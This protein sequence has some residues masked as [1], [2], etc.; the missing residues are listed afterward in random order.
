L[1]G[2]ENVLDT[3]ELAYEDYLSGMKYKDIADKHGLTLSAVKSRATRIWSNRKHSSLPKLQPKEK[4]LHP[5]KPDKARKQAKVADKKVATNENGETN[6]HNPKAHPGNKHAVGNKGGSGGPIGNKRALI[7][8]AYETILFDDLTDEQRA[9]IAAVTTDIESSHMAALQVAVARE[10]L[11]QERL[12]KVKSAKTE[13]LDHVTTEE[14]E[15][16]TTY[17]GS[18]EV[19][20]RSAAYQGGKTTE[21]RNNT[22]TEMKPTLDR[23]L[24]IEAGRSVNLRLWLK[25]SE[26][27]HKLDIDK[28]KM[29]ITEDNTQAGEAEGAVFISGEGDLVD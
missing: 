12:A 8:G 24:E 23:E 15:T 1:G 19:G 3:W 22:I 29:Q 10:L 2:G 14:G 26:Q 4:K 21:I 13:F 18:G 5:D 6:S 9:K 11:M 7:H 16:T 27:L 25:A 17:T 28:R 20:K